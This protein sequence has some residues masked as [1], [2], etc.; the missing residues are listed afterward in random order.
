MFSGQPVISSLSIYR[1]FCTSKLRFEQLYFNKQINKMEKN[2]KTEFC[3]INNK[4]YL[5]DHRPFK[6][7]LSKL[8]FKKM[9]DFL[10]HI[11]FIHTY[12]FDQTGS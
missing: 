10:A 9:N 2:P 7:I 1:W 12:H 6:K 3:K 4:K 8:S 5:K 11:S